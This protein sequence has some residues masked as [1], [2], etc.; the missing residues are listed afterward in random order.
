[1]IEKMRSPAAIPWLMF[2]NWSMNV[3]TGA[4]D[5]GEDGHEGDEP[6]GVERPG[7]DERASEYEDHADGRDAEEFAHGRGELL[8]AGHREGEPCE[9]F[10]DVV[11]FL[12]DV[13]GCVVALDDLD[14]REGFVERGDHLAH[15]LL[16]GAGGVPE[17][18]D[19]A[20][21]E[22]GHDGEE[23]HRE[24][25]ELPRDGDHHDDVT[26]DEE[27]LPEGDLE[28]IG[29][30][31]LDDSDVGGDFGDDIAFPLVGEVPDVHVHD[32]GEHFVAHFLECSGA[33]VLH[34]PGTEVAEEVAQE[35]DADGDDGQEQE[36]VLPIV[37][38][39]HVGV[40]EVEEG[41]QVLLVELHGRQFFDILKGVVRVEHGVQDRDDQHER[42]GVEQRVEERV[43]EIGYGVFLDRPGEAQQPHVS[44]EHS[45]RFGVCAISQ[46][47]RFFLLRS[48]PR[49][50]SGDFGV[51]LAVPD[52]HQF[53]ANIG[54]ITRKAK[55]AR[56]FGQ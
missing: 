7:G 21:D 33:H 39:E 12:L 27:G 37:L 52:R 41:C 40:G 31:E 17:F 44:L 54:I 16:V 32:A 42:Q 43:E 6:S 22:Q 18:L 55:K 23:E 29:D 8:A 48:V 4:C 47:G 34:G 5:L 24:Y 50:I 30:A 14:T 3:R 2:A 26:D 9:V 10:A 53:P 11:V 51:G 15:A 46:P 19:D 13:F 38:L 28:G 49:A 1:M 45:V 35:A 56:K 36:D 20:A 25:G